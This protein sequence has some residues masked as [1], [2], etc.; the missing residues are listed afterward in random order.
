MNWQQ[1]LKLDR[2]AF[3]KLLSEKLIDKTITKEQGYALMTKWKRENQ[4][5]EHSGKQDYTR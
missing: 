1:A 4:S 2:R 3:D 5:K